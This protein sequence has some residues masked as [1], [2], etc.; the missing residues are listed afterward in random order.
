M[1][2]PS[3]NYIFPSILHFIFTI[4]DD[5]LDGL[6]PIGLYDSRTKCEIP[7]RNVITCNYYTGVPDQVYQC[8]CGREYTSKGSLTVHRI[9][10]CRKK[11]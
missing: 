9:W 5:S 2:V 3:L 8:T 10:E 11:S 6:P 4:L 7:N 1:L